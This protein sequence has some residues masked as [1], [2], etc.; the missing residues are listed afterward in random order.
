MVWLKTGIFSKADYDNPDYINMR[1]IV[2]K[3][4]QKPFNFVS[5]RLRLITN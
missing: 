1:T 4:I 2:L 5:T 3:Q